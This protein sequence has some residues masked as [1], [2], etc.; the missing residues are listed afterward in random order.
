LITFRMLLK[1]SDFF[2]PAAMITIMTSVMKKAR[3]S[4]GR[5]TRKRRY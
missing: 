2:T 4:G 1:I 5:P 3:K